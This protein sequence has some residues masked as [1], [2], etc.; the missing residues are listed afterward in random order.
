MFFLGIVSIQCKIKCD[1]PTEPRRSTCWPPLI[2]TRKITT[3]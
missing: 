3:F 1:R 2:S